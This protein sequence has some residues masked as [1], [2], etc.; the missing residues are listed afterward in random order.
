[1]VINGLCTFNAEGMGLIPAWE[2]KIPQAA[3]NSHKIYICFLH[4]VS[5]QINSRK[6]NLFSKE[7]SYLLMSAHESKTCEGSPKHLQQRSG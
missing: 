5:P 1:M 4:E 6:I 3:G 7:K 2:N